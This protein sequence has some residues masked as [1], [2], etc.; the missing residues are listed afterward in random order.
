MCVQ[1]W[2]GWIRGNCVLI[3]AVLRVVTRRVVILKIQMQWFDLRCSGINSRVELG[4]W[5]LAP[6][7]ASGW[8]QKRALRSRAAWADAWGLFD[9]CRGD[10]DSMLCKVRELK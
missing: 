5:P 1:R 6:V 7:A 2:Q 3:T 9:R 4:V 8:R 10:V